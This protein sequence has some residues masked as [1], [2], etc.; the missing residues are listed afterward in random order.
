[1]HEHRIE[2]YRRTDGRKVYFWLDF[3]IPDLRLDIEA[4]G[5]IWHKFFDLKAR[6]RRRDGVLKEKYGIKVVRLKSSD[7]R[8]KRLGRILERVIE[9]RAFEIAKGE[10]S[11]SN[12]A[13]S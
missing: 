5:E 11:L 1:M 7:T 3:Y 8:K 4:D 9:K 13:A 12:H 10:M 6:D 2:A